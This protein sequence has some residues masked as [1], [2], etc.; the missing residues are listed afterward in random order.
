[1][2]YCKLKNIWT[3]EWECLACPKCKAPSE[4]KNGMFCENE[5]LDG[6]FFINYDEDNDDNHLLPI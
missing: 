1:M 4:R 2:S 5:I 6:S 3:T